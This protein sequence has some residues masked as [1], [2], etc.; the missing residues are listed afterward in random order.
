MSWKEEVNELQKKLIRDRSSLIG[1]TIAS[2]YMD[3]GMV[4]LR[5]EDGTYTAFEADVGLDE[6]ASVGFVHILLVEYLYNVGILSE[7][8]YGEHLKE[9]DSNRKSL[10][11]R[12]WEELNKEFGKQD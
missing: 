9:Q 1:K 2:V 6:D 4:C 12:Q 5:F 3:W 7:E 10:R 11:K 8:L